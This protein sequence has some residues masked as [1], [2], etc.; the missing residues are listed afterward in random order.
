MCT[1]LYNLRMRDFAAGVKDVGCDIV[2]VV[3]RG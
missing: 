2:E 3:S 1:L